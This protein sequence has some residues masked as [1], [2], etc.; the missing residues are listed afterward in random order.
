MTNIDHEALEELLRHASPR[1]SPSKEDEAAARDEVRADW[2]D[3]THKRRMR[4]RV[5]QY[6][7][8]ATVLIGAFAAMNSFRGPTLEVEQVATIQK[9]IGSV[10]LMGEQAELRETG[11]L[12]NVMSGQTIVTGNGAGLA[13]AWDKGGLIRVDANTRIRFTDSKSVFL[14]SGKVYFDSKPSP[15]V[16]D[17]DDVETPEFTLRTEYGDVEHLGTQFMTEIGFDLLVVSVREGEVTI[18]GTFYDHTA[19]PGQQVTL[20]GQQR[21]SVLSIGRAGGSWDWINLTTPP[22]EVDGKSVHEFLRW[23]CR[24][25]GLELEFEGR[26]EIVAREA[27]LKGTIDTV[28]AE[29]LRLRLATAA[30]DWRID[31][32][33]IYISEDR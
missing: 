5:A 10:Y 24:E 27:I 6:A 21:P 20:S 30:L 22:A 15:L 29:A 9:S 26:A 18:D 19:A 28:P 2:R 4:G 14:E 13:L 11:D 32:G 12:S 17:S 31:E 3:I 8:A 7:I 1:L 23:V 16:A 33:V 25:M